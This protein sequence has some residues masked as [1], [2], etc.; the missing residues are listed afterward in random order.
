MKIVTRLVTDA[1]TTNFDNIILMAPRIE[2]NQGIK[3]TMDSLAFHLNMLKT[4][5]DKNHNGSF[6]LQH[7]K[8]KYSKVWLA[9]IPV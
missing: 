3:S 4:V 5:L 7:Y 8:I 9:V 6:S 1:S 2:K